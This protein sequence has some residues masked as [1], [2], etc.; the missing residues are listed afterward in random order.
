MSSELYPY[1][2]RDLLNLI[3]QTPGV[4]SYKN[5][6]YTHIG[7]YEIKIYDK[8]L[9]I[10]FTETGLYIIIEAPERRIIPSKSIYHEDHYKFK[11][12]DKIWLKDS[13]DSEELGDNTELLSLVDTP[14][15][16]AKYGFSFY[17][18]ATRLI[19]LR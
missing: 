19:N 15:F 3:L 11:R 4:A 13:W 1:L 14:E 17:A 2:R 7:Y 9:Y 18:L 5:F 6:A 8:F 10:T 16:K 12:T